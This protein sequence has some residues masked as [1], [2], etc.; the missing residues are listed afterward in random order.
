LEYAATCTEYPLVDTDAAADGA[1]L[2]SAF[3]TT[4]AGLT[5]GFSA[6]GLATFV[7]STILGFASLASVGG[8]GLCVW[9]TLS[10]D[11]ALALVRDADVAE[12]VAV[13]VGAVLVA[14]AGFVTV[15]GLDGGVLLT[16]GALVAAT[17]ADGHRCP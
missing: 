8:F 15:V 7:G 5:A 13:V 4:D 2:G 14:G 16:G 3:S 1:G 6:A 11:V 12:L 9:A 10:C 17:A